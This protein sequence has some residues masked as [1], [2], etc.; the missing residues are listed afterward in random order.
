MIRAF[1]TQ[2][3]LNINRFVN[4]NK[5]IEMVSVVNNAVFGLKVSSRR[6]AIR[7]VPT[8]RQNSRLSGR[9]SGWADWLAVVRQAI[10]RPVARLVGRGVNRPVG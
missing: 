7:W 1:A 4:T 6:A 10:S 3:V 8:S 9:T 5:L 2:A